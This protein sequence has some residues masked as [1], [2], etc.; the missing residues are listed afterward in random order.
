MKF[1]NLTQA[2]VVFL[3]FTF[4]Y[5]TLLFTLTTP[6]WRSYILKLFRFKTGETKMNYLVQYIRNPET[7][8]ILGTIVYTKEGLMGMS[9]RS[10][11]DQVNKKLGIQIALNRAINSITKK[12][13]NK[14]IP[15]HNF[16]DIVE[17][18][19]ID[20]QVRAARYFKNN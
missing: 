15:G 2:D 7:R 16:Y 10:N 4:F 14:R 3:G 13:P 1:L 6:E 18:S 5:V 8:E 19:S 11:K 17:N 20:L 9:F 12:V